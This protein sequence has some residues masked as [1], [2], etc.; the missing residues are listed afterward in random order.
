MTLVEMLIVT[1]MLGLIAFVIAA[2]FVTILRITPQ[3]EYRI[4]DA[5]ST[6][7]LQTWLA[8]D[9]ASTPANVY[10]AGTGVGYVDSSFPSPVAAGVLPGAVCTTTGTHVLYMSWKDGSTLYHSQYTIEGDAT[11]GYEVVRTICGGDSAAISITGDVAADACT[12]T[13][14]SQVTITDLNADLVN[15]ATVNLCFVSIQTE[16]LSAGGSQQ[17]ITMSI[18]SRNGDY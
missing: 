5:R 11:S 6:R 8:R 10:N 2:V 12:S 9:V 7:G 14:R 3:T 18:V 16:G 13:P 4:D 17:E 1:S 15:E